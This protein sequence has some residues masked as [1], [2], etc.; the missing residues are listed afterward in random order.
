MKPNRFLA[1]GFLAILLFGGPAAFSDAVTDWNAVMTQALKSPPQPPPVQTRVS[2][3]V[4]LAVFEAVNGVVRKYEPFIVTDAAP[5][6]ARAEAAAVQAA[7]TMLSLAYPSQQ[8]AYDAQLAV[9]L[10][11]IPGSA[12]DSDSIARGREWG[13]AVANAIWAARANDGFNTTPPATPAT[14]SAGYW[15]HSSKLPGPTTVG[16][17][18]LE[19]APFFIDDPSVYVPGPPY[20][21]ADRMAAMATAAYAADVNEVKDYGGA[22]S[23]ARTADQEAEA[24]FINA[25][26]TSD[27][28][29]LI[30]GLLPKSN[31]L[32]DN[33]RVFAL[34]NTA[35]FDATIPIFESKWSYELWRPY[36]AI[37]FADE[38]GNNDT[39]KD[40]AWMPLRTT[41]PH[42]EYLSGHCLYIPTL[43]R[44]AARLLG[45]DRPVE[46]STPSIA[47][48][49]TYPSLHALALATIEARVNIGFHFR[50]T[51]EI[52]FMIAQEVADEVVD[53]ALLPTG[54]QGH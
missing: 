8:A 46:V 28:N 43:A 9:S 30:V 50:E 34:M 47:Q 11:A 54:N 33:A 38:D 52:S 5:P 2:T 51:C 20:G 10:A 17:N 23:V 49:R 36:Q 44:V 15:R 39:V 18:F 48:T 26:D 21:I 13:A 14:T 12:G 37:Q 31:S 24:L 35:G 53:T 4:S 40:A 3:M 25:F 22:V 42:P 27:F 19:T 41:P 45:D 7:Y 29:R 16:L 1:A 32:V 6:G